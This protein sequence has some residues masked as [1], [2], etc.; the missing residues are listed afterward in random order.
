MQSISS[1]RKLLL[2]KIGNFQKLPGGG[3]DPNLSPLQERVNKLQPELGRLRIAN[4]EA[5]GRA[6]AKQPLTELVDQ[7][8]AVDVE[9]EKALVHVSFSSSSLVRPVSP[10]MFQFCVLC[11]HV[12][13]KSKSDVHPFPLLHEGCVEHYLPSHEELCSDE[14][15][16]VRVG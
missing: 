16:F 1:A 13:A 9:V 14:W 2:Q 5:E 3:T 12:S 11:P 6:R 8:E 10:S 7:F 4:K 15:I